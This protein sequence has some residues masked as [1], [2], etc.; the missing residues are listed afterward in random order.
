MFR[1]AY[2]GPGDALDGSGRR[3]VIFDVIGPD[4]ETSLLGDLKLVLHVNPN[5]MRWSYQRVIE[6]TQTEGGWVE[7]H[8]GSA[9]TEVSFEAATGGFMRLYAGLVAT[10]GPTA[11]NDL[12]PA[13]QRALD[14][15]GTRR[16]TIAYDKYLDLL[17]LFRFNGSI[18]DS[19]GNIA[20]QG[21]VRIIYD[22]GS[23]WG[24]F[25]TFEVEE[26]SEKPYQFKLTAAFTVDRETHRVRGGVPYTPAPQST[27]SRP[28]SGA[29]AAPGT[30]APAPIPPP[31]AFRPAG[32]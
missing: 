29:G 28:P 7:A 27:A 15:G 30:Q 26:S 6:R 14:V 32:R 10:T 1:S 18:Y 17:A 9:P 20:L 11:S 31:A 19:A 4:R 8:W 13:S 21:Q 23:W 22:G 12:L 3:P 16:E 2:R 5:S 25:S 24:W